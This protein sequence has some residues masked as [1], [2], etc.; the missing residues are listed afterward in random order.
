MKAR[1][2]AVIAT[3]RED[4]LELFLRAWAPPPWDETIVIEDGPN[5]SMDVSVAGHSRIHH[6]AWADIEAAPEVVDPTAFSRCDAAIK[7]YG[8]W[9]AM[10]LGVDVII[11]LD[12]DCLPAGPPEHF[13]SAHLAALTPRLRWVPSIKESPTRGLPYFDRGA[14]PGAVA[15]MGLWC[16][17]ADYDGVQTLALHRAGQTIDSYDPPAGNR[18]MHPQN[19][20]PWCAMN[21]AFKRE[22]TPLM[23]MPKMGAGSPYSRFDDI[24]GGVILQRCC[25]HLALSLAV[26]EPHIRHVRASDPLINLEREAPGIRANEDFWKL[27]EATPLDTRHATPLTCVEAVSAHLKSP[28]EDRQLGRN[29][30]LV[31]YARAEGARLQSWCEMFRMAGWT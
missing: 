9:A 2:A 23:Y 13:V 14:I 25:R 4:C 16:G 3:N 22:I 18:L 7:M 6:Y 5:R 20:W 10:R 21:I 15:N 30:T 17:V 19:Y 31:S 11:A 27:I 26:G 28:S 8:F 1:T 24:W 29:P 12:D